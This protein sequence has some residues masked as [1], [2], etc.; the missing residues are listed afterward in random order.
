MHVLGT[1]AESHDTRCYFVSV[2]SSILDKLIYMYIS[3]LLQTVY[4]TKCLSGK[5]CGVDGQ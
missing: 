3:Q 5:K 2:N 1:K 4:V